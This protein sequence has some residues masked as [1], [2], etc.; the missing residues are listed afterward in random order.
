V[1]CDEDD[2]YQK[3][4]GQDRRHA[5]DCDHR[6]YVLVRPHQPRSVRS[7]AQT[8]ATGVWRGRVECGDDFFAKTTSYSRFAPVKPL[9]NLDSDMSK[10]FTQTHPR[11]LRQGTSFDSERVSQSVYCGQTSG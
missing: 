3:D 6:L 9:G 4:C 8:V 7:I 2:R 5:A 10:F 1:T 11:K